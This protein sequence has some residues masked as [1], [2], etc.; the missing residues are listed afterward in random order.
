MASA[1]YSL[2]I[3]I[4]ASTEPPSDLQIREI[5][6]NASSDLLNT[7]FTAAEFYCT[8]GRLLFSISLSNW[9]LV[10]GKIKNSLYTMS[11]SPDEHAES[12]ELRALEWINLNARKLSVLLQDLS[13]VIKSF[14]KQVVLTLPPLLRK[15]IWNWI[16]LHPQEFI[17]LHMKRKR[18]EGVSDSLFEHFNELADNN[19][20]KNV[21]LPF[22]TALVILCPDVLA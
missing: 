16:N 8:A 6:L 10:Y 14:K 3:R 5:L 15:A 1:V 9:D 2:A 22:Q 7:E 17:A 20:R 12:A 4:L 19:K 21:V 18:L 11:Q 13:F